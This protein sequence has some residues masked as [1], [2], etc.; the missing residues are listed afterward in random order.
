MFRFRI[1]VICDIHTVDEYGHI[2]M[3]S[4]IF[5]NFSKLWGGIS[6]LQAPLLPAFSV[7]YL[8]MMSF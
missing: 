1:S 5:Q 3:F 2:A 6:V 7:N 4:T 8:E